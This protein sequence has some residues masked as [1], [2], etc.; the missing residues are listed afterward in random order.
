MSRYTEAA[1]GLIHALKDRGCRWNRRRPRGRLRLRV[2]FIACPKMTEAAFLSRPQGGASTGFNA[3]P[4]R[5]EAAYPART[6]AAIWIAAV[7]GG[8]FVRIAGLLHV[9]IDRG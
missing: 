8:G 5:T 2:R 9:R 1:Y 6:E 7:H 4:T 3:C